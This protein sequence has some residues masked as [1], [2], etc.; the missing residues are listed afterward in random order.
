MQLQF[1]ESY[2]VAVAVVLL[3]LCNLQGVL[4]CAKELVRAC[5]DLKGAVVLP[6]LLHARVPRPAAPHVVGAA[7]VSQAAKQRPQ[8]IGG[9][10][11]PAAAVPGAGDRRVIHR[12]PACARRAQHRVDAGVLRGGRE[13]RERA[14]PG[15]PGLDADTL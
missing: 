8:G 2:L 13:P 15:A 12:E 14:L 5:R 10:L 11:L 3:L 1:H 4:L 6:V 9:V 7:A